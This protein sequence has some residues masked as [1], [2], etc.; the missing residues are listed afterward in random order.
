MP[1]A[2]TRPP[3]D[4]AALGAALLSLAGDPDLRA[5][6]GDA[7]RI[8]ATRDFSLDACVERYAALY[9]GLLA[10]KATP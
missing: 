9:R 1:R 7:A 8:R 5:R 3:R 10:L 6:L 2:V 4:P